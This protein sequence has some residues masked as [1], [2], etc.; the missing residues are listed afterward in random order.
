[1][2]RIAPDAVD[3]HQFAG[4]VACR[5]LPDESEVVDRLRAALALWRGSALTDAG[6]VGWGVAEAAE[7]DLQRQ[8]LGHPLRIKMYTMFDTNLPAP[9]PV[10]ESG[11]NAPSIT[12]EVPA[13]GSPI[14]GAEQDLFFTIDRGDCL[15]SCPSPPTTYTV[16]YTT[17]LRNLDVRRLVI[18]TQ[19]DYPPADLDEVRCE[20]WVDF[21][22]SLNMDFGSID[23]GDSHKFKDA[24]RDINFDTEVQFE[25]IELD[26]SELT[27]DTTLT[28]KILPSEIHPASTVKVKRVL[29]V[30]DDGDQTDPGGEYRIH[31]TG[32]G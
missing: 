20:F 14:S 1:M 28:L 3:A 15:V 27:H 7:V 23:E 26:N 29:P 21:A 5:D 13:K 2:L 25:C 24:F 4:V 30:Y 8:E 32:K 19:N 18:L 31:Y 11:M 22:T 10:L 6:L 9:K 16:Q 12:L 17:S